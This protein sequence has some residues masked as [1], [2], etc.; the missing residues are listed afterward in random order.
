VS[1]L[2]LLAGRIACAA[3]ALIDGKA[4]AGCR[5]R[6]G[7]D[8]ID[9]AVPHRLPILWRLVVLLAQVHKHGHDGNM[10]SDVKIRGAVLECNDQKVE[11]GAAMSASIKQGIPIANKGSRVEQEHKE[12]IIKLMRSRG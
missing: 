12:R 2:A 7:L 4:A 5:D 8:G 11:S 10:S 3:G 9:R 1:L 6:H